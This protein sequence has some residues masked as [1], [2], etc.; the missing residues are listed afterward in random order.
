MLVSTV[1]SHLQNRWGLLSGLSFDLAL[2]QSWCP[3]HFVWTSPLY[4]LFLLEPI[5]FL[6]VLAL[7]YLWWKQHVYSWKNNPSLHV[8]EQVLIQIRDLKLTE[9]LKSYQMEQTM[10]KMNRLHAFAYVYM[11]A[12]MHVHTQQ[13]I[14]VGTEGGRFI[15]QV[16]QRKINIK[17]IL[18]GWKWEFKL[19]TL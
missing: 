16:G 13:V 5:I 12:Q 3:D 17:H 8:C 15:L 4:L 1:L 7:L 18:R 11:H 9:E 19:L 14:W 10:Q 2:T 6:H